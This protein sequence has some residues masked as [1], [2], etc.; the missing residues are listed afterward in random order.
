MRLIN[1]TRFIA[2]AVAVILFTTMIYTT[3]YTPMELAGAISI[4]AG[5]YIVPRTVR[6]SSPEK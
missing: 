3:T 5:I 2:F 4:L 1:S 6:G